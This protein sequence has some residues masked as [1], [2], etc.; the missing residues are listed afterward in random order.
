MTR[1]GKTG[2]FTHFRM[3]QGN[4]RN[5]PVDLEDVTRYMCAAA[6]LDPGFADATIAE[7][8][9]DE[10]RA[11]VPSVGY[12]VEPVLRHCFRARALRLRRD[13]A[14]LAVLAVGL[15]L[16][17]QIFVLW[18]FLG[19]IV[20]SARRIRAFLRSLTVRRTVGGRAAGRMVPI[21]VTAFTLLVVCYCGAGGIALLSKSG[22][23][24]LGGDDPVGLP[25]MDDGGQT[26][27]EVPDQGVGG[28]LLRMTFVLVLALVVLFWYRRTLYRILTVELG[29]GNEEHYPPD[30]PNSQLE[31]RVERVAAA[32]YGNIALHSGRNPFI[33]GGA[34]HNSW[35]MSLELLP[36]GTRSSRSE[37][38]AI[39]PVALH[40]HIRQ[41]LRGMYGET[42]RD[43]EKITG[44]VLS[45]HIVA[46][47][48]RECDELIEQ[49]R[50]RPFSVASRA[51]IDAI[52]RHPQGHLRYYLRAVVGSEG[53]EILGGGGPKDV[54]AARQDQQ[55]AVSTF[56]YLA[57]EGGMLYA[58]FVATVMP[59][60]RPEYMVIDRWVPERVDLRAALESFPALFTD[61]P[62]APLGAVRSVSTMLGYGRRMRR[63]DRAC[64]EFRYYDY[65][66]RLS[67]R[68]LAARGA[69][70]SYLQDLD[71]EKYYKLI[72]RAVTSA[73]LEF[74]ADHNV[75]TTEYET[76]A[77]TV[78]NAGVIITGGQFNGPVAAGAG[79]VAS[80]TSS[81]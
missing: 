74:L 2:Y 53:R 24:G 65:G 45:D 14:L 19:V 68:E 81:T 3:R 75:D 26:V 31:K 76:R 9:E 21:L 7:L 59:P 57:V 36:A 80:Q 66:A 6:Y 20:A 71:A 61:L 33:G 79:A 12:D 67:V 15:L 78:L 17:W 70:L 18:L 46:I 29:R 8:V 73:V 28:L 4:G 1:T 5:E 10:H 30:A 62:A 43:E 42:L 13:V 48:E 39:D 52:I 16:A 11:V 54:V 50:Y 77:N 49:R 40:G 56:L 51:A 23:P 25:S 27:P 44:L 60:L 41:R 35:S 55:I 47:G 64:Q 69:P 72:E 37:R 63:A 38:I 32:Q 58:E 22:L 34:V